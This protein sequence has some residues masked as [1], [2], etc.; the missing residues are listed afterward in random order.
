MRYKEELEHLE[1]FEEQ[2][3][4]QVALSLEI[5]AHVLEFCRHPGGFGLTVVQHGRQCLVG[6][7]FSKTQGRLVSFIKRDSSSSGPQAQLQFA[8]STDERAMTGTFHLPHL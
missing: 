7:L 3:G 6:R 1:C 5:H 4:F 2:A 8:G